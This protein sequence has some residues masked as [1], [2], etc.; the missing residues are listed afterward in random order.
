MVRRP[1]NK[2]ETH[3]KL[4]HIE[5][6]LVFLLGLEHPV[7]LETVLPLP[8]IRFLTLSDPWL[9]SRE[10]LHRGVNYIDQV[11]SFLQLAHMYAPLRKQVHLRLM[12]IK[13][14]PTWDIQKLDL[15]HKTSDQG[16]EFQLC[17]IWVSHIDHGLGQ[18]R[19]PPLTLPP[20][21]VEQFR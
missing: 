9:I 1:F 11:L 4:S 18:L 16:I 15:L 5:I 19:D 7:S 14:P 13:L 12:G 8:T 2:S 3:N 21:F 10:C 20:Y 6:S 17:Y